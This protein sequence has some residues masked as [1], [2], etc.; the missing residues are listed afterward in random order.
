VTVVR[1]LL[2]TEVGLAKLGGRGISAEEAGQIP[3]NP[4]L[5]ASNPRSG[6]RTSTA[7]LMRR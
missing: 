2:I 3:R 7:V 6:G 4:H 5:I 1:D